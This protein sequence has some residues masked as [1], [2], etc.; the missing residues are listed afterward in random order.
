MSSTNTNH[1]VFIQNIDETPIN[2]EGIL[3]APLDILLGI[4]YTFAS[5]ARFVAELPITSKLTQPMGLLHGGVSVALAE[6]VGSFASNLHAQP[7]TAYVGQEIN[8]NHLK[9][10][11]VGDTLIATAVPV[12]LAYTTQV[13]LFILRFFVSNCETGLIPM[14]RF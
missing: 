5:K 1:S 13:C 10:G 4:T 6:S 3:P 9:P 2:L 7:G 11:F 12:Y 14:L 8:A